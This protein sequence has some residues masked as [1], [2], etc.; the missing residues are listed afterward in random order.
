MKVQVTAM[1]L[2]CDCCGET[3]ENYNGCGIEEVDDTA[4]IKEES[5]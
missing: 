2:V 3:Y 1:K 4:E 5:L